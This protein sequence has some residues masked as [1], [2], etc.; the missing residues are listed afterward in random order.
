MQIEKAFQMAIK[1]NQDMNLKFG[2]VSAVTTS[3][4]RVSITIS[5][6]ATVITGIRYL[7]SYSPTVSDV[8]VCLVNKGDIIVLGK[9][10]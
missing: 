10:A 5:G 3:P 1:K 9:L 4:N 2:V 7:A 6:S 8:I